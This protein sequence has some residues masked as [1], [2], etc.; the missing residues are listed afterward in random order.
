MKHSLPPLTS[1]YYN[2]LFHSFIE[3]KVLFYIVLFSYL[4]AHTKIK[5]ISKYRAPRTDYFLNILVINH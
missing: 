4:Y 2:I 1:T 5:P 3:I